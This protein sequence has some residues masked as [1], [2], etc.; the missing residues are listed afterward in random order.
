MLRTPIL[1]IISSNF[2]NTK[3]TGGKSNKFVQEDYGW[4]VI[5]K[6]TE[7]FYEEIIKIFGV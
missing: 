5:A 6:K 7:K 2:G 3:R 4:D 1:P